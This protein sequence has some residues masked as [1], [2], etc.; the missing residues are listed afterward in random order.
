[1]MEGKYVAGLASGDFDQYD[2]LGRPVITIR[3]RAGAEMKLDDAQL[4]PPYEPGG[5]TD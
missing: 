4:P 5:P 3:Y 1:M 2:E